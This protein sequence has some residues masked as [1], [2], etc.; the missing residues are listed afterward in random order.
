MSNPNQNIVQQMQWMQA[1]LLALAQLDQ[2]QG[3]C[4][5]VSN[6][7]DFWAQASQDTESPLVFICW[8]GEKPWSSSAN[9]S[10]VTY[11]VRR[12]W[13]V[14]VKWGRGHDEDRG[15]TQDNF[16]PFVEAVRDTIRS[17]VGVSQ[18]TGIDYD[19]CEPW[20]MGTQVIDAFIITFYSHNDLPP[21]LTTPDD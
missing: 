18:D 19:G 11:R 4:K 7:R 13:M 8:G 20:S 14:G 3:D 15:V 1:E 5:R 17:W 2:Y 9:L 6:L 10:A 21:I 16:L 12:K